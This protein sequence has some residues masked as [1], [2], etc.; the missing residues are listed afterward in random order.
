MTVCICIH[1]YVSRNGYQVAVQPSATVGGCF[2][3]ARVEL[4][5]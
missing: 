4:T 5:L 3:S 2:I 1:L